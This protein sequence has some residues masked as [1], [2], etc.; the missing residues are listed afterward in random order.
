MINYYYEQRY[1]ILNTE[2]DCACCGR[3]VAPYV[4]GQRADDADDE[5]DDKQPPA[6]AVAAGADAPPGRHGDERRQ[7]GADVAPVGRRRRPEQGDAEGGEGR[8]PDGKQQLRTDATISRI[9]KC[10]QILRAN[11]LILANS[12]KF[13]RHFISTEKLVYTRYYQD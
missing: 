1:W 7:G 2:R 3:Q 6:V 11:T 9:I 13:S 5:R 4:G 12:V 8:Q 10:T